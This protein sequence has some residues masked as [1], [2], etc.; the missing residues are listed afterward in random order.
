MKKPV[1][2]ALLAAGGLGLFGICF[3]AFAA[4]TG[5]PMH[6]APVVG[7]LF[8][9]PAEEPEPEAVAE[10]A[11]RTPA[12]LPER[13]NTTLDVVNA[14]LGLL[15]GFSI[16]APF[17]RSELEQLVDD[18]MHREEDLEQR[19]AAVAE[20]E[21]ELQEQLT[22]LAGQ[23]ADLDALREEIDVRAAELE[24]RALELR[25]DERALEADEALRYANLAALYADGDVK[26]AASDLQAMTAEEAALVLRNLEDDRALELLRALPDEARREYADAW[27]VAGN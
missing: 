17:S 12:S 4:V 23:A 19:L 6:E 7:G 9:E 2:I 1:E 14:N 11:E 10:R 25:R 27:A 5:A 15:G 20:R 18:L 24:L 21:Q 13:R 16:P 26:Q 8:P 3:V 22:L